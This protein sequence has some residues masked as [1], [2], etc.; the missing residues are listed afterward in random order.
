MSEAIL[1]SD[2]QEYKLV[3][4]VNSGEIVNSLLDRGLIT[5]VGRS[6]S[7]GR[8]LLYGT[9]TDFLRIFGLNALEELPKMKELEELRLI[10]TQSIAAELGSA[11]IDDQ[12]VITDED[13]LY[14]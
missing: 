1:L 2:I 6:D 3:R 12:I 5:I 11:M 10:Q 8:P 9:T 7:L 14:I 13:V 4:G